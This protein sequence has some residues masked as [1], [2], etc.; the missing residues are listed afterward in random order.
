MFG[1]GETDRLPAE[2]YTAEAAAS[3]YARVLDRARRALAAGHAVIVDAVFARQ[4]ERE[5]IARLAAEA[6][7][8]FTGLWLEAPTEQLLSRVTARVADASDADASVVKRQLSYA[9]GEMDW[10]PVDAAG[11]PEATLRAAPAV[12]RHLT[13][14]VAHPTE[15]SEH[16]SMTI[17]NLEFLLSPRS[18]ALIGASAEAGSDRQHRRRAISRAPASRA[19]SGLVNPKHA[20]IDGHA[21]C[22]TI[23]GAAGRARSRRRS[24]HRRTPFRG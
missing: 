13:S 8:P 1:V 3:V 23:G 7:V 18:V 16:P 21:C 24:R 4:H 20:A 11:D 14:A 17:R 12:A 2:A 10:R 15:Q 6:G 9:T 5:A 19:R 22:Q